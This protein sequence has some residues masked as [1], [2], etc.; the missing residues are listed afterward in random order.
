M[1][2][3]IRR[4]L[5]TA[6]AVAVANEI[7]YSQL[8]A[9]AGDGDFG[10]IL[11]LAAARVKGSLD[12]AP[13]GDA[14][15]LLLAA[16]HAVAGVGGTTGP[17]WG[18]GLLRAAESIHL[19][20]GAA[21]RAAADGISELGGA[22]LGDRTLLDALLPVADAFE[23]GDDPV[24]A[25]RAGAEGTAHLAAR[26]GRARYVPGRGVGSIDAGAQ[27]VADLVEAVANPGEIQP[28]RGAAAQAPATRG[29]ASA[30]HV[31]ANPDQL[32][33]DAIAG[34]VMA[35]SGTLR[36][37]TDPRYVARTDLPRP[38]LVALISGGGSGHEPMHAGLIGPGLLAAACPGE[39]FA[40]PSAAQVQAAIEAVDGDAGVL[41]IV[42]N[43][44]GDVLNFR[45]GA[46]LARSADHRVETVL[47]ADDIALDD[48]ALDDPAVDDIADRPTD[49]DG[50]EGVGRRGVAGTIVV[51]KICGA[52][53]E[54][55][56]ELTALA[57]LGKRVSEGTR[58]IGVSV[59]GVTLPSGGAAAITLAPG[60]Q[61]FGVGIHGEPG[62][63]RGPQ[64]P[65]DR[66]VSRMCAA[67]L[68]GLDRSQPVLLYTNG[69]GGIAGLELSAV[70][71]YAVRELEAAGVTVVRSMA[72]S[73]VTSLGMVGFSLTVSPL[74]AELTELWDAPC[75]S[76]AWTVA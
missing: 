12:A 50:S 73:L 71:G 33:D 72:G 58:T 10:A 31:V 44:T 15:D 66:L 28:R 27:A 54:A 16:A 24:P 30:G 63:E 76:S 68:A 55:G 18:I 37:T 67:L 29:V 42:K 75:R 23:V 40:S 48:P 32:V 6:C 1:T 34:L 13:E 52:A 56:A 11:A 25:A 46:D 38:G 43:Y 17:I 64:E 2:A 39:V 19:G 36:A 70:H 9:A 51:E 3:D 35:S 59:S 61:E 45:L 74:D 22:K 26:R 47:V 21:V 5:L 53:A 69:L 8:D 20:A 41:L 65:A 62:S 14:R 7:E 57:A 49:P 60:E 4:L